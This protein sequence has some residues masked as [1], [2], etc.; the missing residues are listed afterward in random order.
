MKISLR[1]GAGIVGLAAALGLNSCG[2]SS[3]AGGSSTPPKACASAAVTPPP[4]AGG[5]DPLFG[6]QWHLENTGQRGGTPG[7]DVRVR[8]V[9]EAAQNPN[10]GEGVRIAIVDDGLEITHEDL[11]ANVVSNASYDY[12]VP[13]VCSPTGGQHGTA[14]AGVAAAR[15]DNG[16]GGR[17]AAP[18]ASLVGYNLLTAKNDANE[19]DAMTRDRT[20]N[21][22]SSN[23]WGAPDDRG[24]LD[25][26]AQTWYDAINLGLAEGRNGL[27]T[28]YVWAAGNG[29][30]TVDNSNYDGQANYRGVVAV[31]AVGDDGT[32]ADY[33]EPGANLLVCAPSRGNNG[34]GI[35]T[36]DRTGAAGYDPTNY[37][38][39]FSGTSSAAPLAAG[40]IGLLL[41]ARPALTWRDVRLILAETA[42]QTDITDRAWYTFGTA[43]T[44][45]F[46]HNY[47]FGVIDAQAAVARAANWSPLPPAS[48]PFPANTQVAVQIPDNGPEV[49]S[50]I[51]VANSGIGKIEFID[52]V[53]TS[54]HTFFGDL[55][56]RLRNDTTGS[57]SELA[58]EH[59]CFDANGNAIDCG[60]GYANGWRFGSMR[61]LGEAADGNWTLLVQDMDAGDI[62]SFTWSITFHGRP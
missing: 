14:V 32:K 60:S 8:P 5:G 4:A 23:S 13:G 24:T 53:F 43:P 9:W 36:T 58:S 42:R 12:E 15:N 44:Y 26:P 48:K 55:R 25:A 54:A 6:D 47:G 49:T 61:H 52:V 18:R 40:V 46:N 31:C 16:V 17:G 11:I 41:K 19:A 62:G 39:N 38:S 29:G 50:G 28:I 35:T 57:I 34:H 56:I 3:D 45:H 20:A 1:V 10:L 27:G 59:D 2:G 22:I 30:L 51:T 7:E 21:A 37:F 33:S